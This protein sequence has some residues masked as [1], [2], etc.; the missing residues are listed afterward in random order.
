MFLFYLKTNNSFIALN[1]TKHLSRNMANSFDH[2]AKGNSGKLCN[3][4]CFFYYFK[5]ESS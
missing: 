1:F 5:N 3:S 2:K 4:H